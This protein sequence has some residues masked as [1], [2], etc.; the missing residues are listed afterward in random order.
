MAET[1]ADFYEVYEI[2]CKLRKECHWDMEQTI[3]TLKEDL[4]DEYNELIQAIDNNDMENMKEEIGD[5]MWSLLLMTRIAEDEG[6]FSINEVF[7]EL[8][9]KMIRRHPHVFGD[10]KASNLEETTRFFKEAKQR[11]KEEKLSKKNNHG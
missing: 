9:A 2:I 4:S 11:E 1:S 7:D 10:V 8:K 3:P 6:H 5:L